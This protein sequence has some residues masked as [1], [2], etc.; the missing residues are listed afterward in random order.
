MVMDLIV[1]RLAEDWEIKPSVPAAQLH[2]S[3]AIPR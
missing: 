2:T 1:D 3:S